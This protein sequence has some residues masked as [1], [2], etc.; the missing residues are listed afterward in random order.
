MRYP[1]HG[2]FGYKILA[3]LIWRPYYWI[4]Y[5]QEP[6]LRA[7]MT[8]RRIWGGPRITAERRSELAELHQSLQAML[9]KP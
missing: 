9:R 6:E 2:S 1:A 3:T 7:F 5:R 4:T 8:R